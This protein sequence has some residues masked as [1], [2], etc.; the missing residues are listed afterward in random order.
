MEE[1]VEKVNTPEVQETVTEAV[2][3]PTVEVVE[4]VKSFNKEKAISLLQELGLLFKEGYVISGY[5]PLF[6][7]LHKTITNLE[8]RVLDEI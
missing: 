6:S 3:E 7:H 1:K 2:V 8:Y 4:E 5:N